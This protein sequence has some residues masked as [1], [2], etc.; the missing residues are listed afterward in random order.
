MYGQ[1]MELLPLVSFAFMAIILIIGVI[2]VD[3]FYP[4][5][6]QTG[7]REYRFS[8][9]SSSTISRTDKRRS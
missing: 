3:Y 8:K 6:S 4:M 5:N 1:N 2:A 9:C 7:K